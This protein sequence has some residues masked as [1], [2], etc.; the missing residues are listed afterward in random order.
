MDSVENKNTI[1]TSF[2]EHI[3]EL[4]GRILWIAL[5]SASFGG[6]AYGIHEKLLDLIQRPLGQTLYFTS[7]TGGFSFIFKLCFV[8]G[9]VLSLPVIFYHIFGFLGPLLNRNRKRT[10]IIYTIWSTLLA[11]VGLVFAYY[12][13]LPAALRFLTSIGGNNIESL[14]GANEYFNFALAYL[15]G[16]AVLFQLPLVVTFI[17]RIKP[18]K[19]SGMM[20][21]QK[22]VILGSLMSAAVL[23]PTP[24]PFNMLIMAV[25]M[26]LLYQFSI[27][28]VWFINR[29]IVH[30]VEIKRPVASVVRVNKH[31]TK[32]L[33][34]SATYGTPPA[35]SLKEHLPSRAI[36]DI[37]APPPRKS[38]TL[39]QVQRP[40][41][42]FSRQV[43]MQ[44]KAPK[45]IGNDFL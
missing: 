44:S 27:G 36:R 21:A 39:K 11:G 34:R 45:L 10:I 20:K 43:V 8:A 13:S 4:R 19:P 33:A 23:T 30:E 18:L 14:I 25:P 2:I 12:V 3:H 29:N 28:L 42:S 31:I 16:F 22:Y 7:P 9:L 32:A 41:I 17:N 1:Q 24:D 35:P 5:F 37:M 40:K 38:Q 15:A 6:L 26:V